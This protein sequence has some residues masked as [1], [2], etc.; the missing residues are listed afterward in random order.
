MAIYDFGGMHLFKSM[1]VLSA[2]SYNKP[3][4]YNNV[5]VPF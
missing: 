4:T 5:T 2:S 3:H 1:L